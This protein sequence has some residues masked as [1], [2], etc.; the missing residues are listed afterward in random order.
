MTMRV[1]GA[2]IPQLV[3][4]ETTISRVAPSRE[5]SA[6]GPFESLVTEAIDHANALDAQAGAKVDALAAGKS[7]DIHGTMIATKEAEISVKLLGTIRNQ[8]LDAFH[9]IWRTSV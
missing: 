4:Q 6:A 8:L 9:E 1:T 3:P 2:E 7:D 5:A